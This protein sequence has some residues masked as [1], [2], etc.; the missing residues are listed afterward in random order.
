MGLSQIPL[1][2]RQHC[3]AAGALLL[4][5]WPSGAECPLGVA[6][7]KDGL[8]DHTTPPTFFCSPTYPDPLPHHKELVV[9][10]TTPRHPFPCV[11]LACMRS[12]CLDQVLCPP[13]PSLFLRDTRISMSCNRDQ[14][15]INF[16][17]GWRRLF[18]VLVRIHSLHAH[19][20]TWVHTPSSG[21]FLH[22]SSSGS[23][24]FPCSPE[25]ARRPRLLRT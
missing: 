15:Q 18:E 14:Q 13:D 9:M 21:T 25:R 4:A 22:A 20:Y 7:K 23:P 6:A 19:G 12:S 3:H 16:Y 8:L 17:L 11:F 2:P 5:R 24:A 1:L 10:T